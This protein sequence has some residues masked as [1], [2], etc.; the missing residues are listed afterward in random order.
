[1]KYKGFTLIELLVVIAIIAI[2]A[3]LLFPV[4]AKAKDA[5]YS[6]KSISNAKQMG[7]AF[8]LYLDDSDDVYPQATDGQPGTDVTGGWVFYSYFDGTNHGI[9]DVTKGSI[10]PYANS[11]DIYQSSGDPDAKV[12]GNSWAINGYLGT[13]S[14]TG[15]NPGKS[16]SDVAYPSSTMLIGEEGCGSPGLF[17]YGYTR[18]SNDGYFNPATDHFQKSHAGGAIVLFCDGHS[19]IVQAQDN[20]VQTICGT[21]A[22]CF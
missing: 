11:R 3:A 15:L 2:L 7:I 14:G 20:F 9:F 6:A 10:Y 8:E 5:A 17:T 18:G 1:M 22:Q 16:Q 4:F 21:T 12:S 13:W 19:K